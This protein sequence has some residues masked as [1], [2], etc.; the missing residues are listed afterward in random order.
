MNLE[1]DIEL[2]NRRKGDP[3]L[4]SGIQPLDKNVF[5][6]QSVTPPPAGGG[7][8]PLTEEE[9]KDAV[10]AIRSI[11]ETGVPA[12]SDQVNEDLDMAAKFAKWMSDKRGS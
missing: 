3:F 5:L 4:P 6:R 12:D 11:W 1:R 2:Q 8:K 10:Y 7:Q 9:K